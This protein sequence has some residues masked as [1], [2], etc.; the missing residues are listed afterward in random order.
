MPVYG[1]NIVRLGRIGGQG[2]CRYEGDMRGQGSGWP[3]YVWAG[4]GAG[5]WEARAFV[6]GVGVVLARRGGWGE[7]YSPQPRTALAWGRMCRGDRKRICKE[8]E[9]KKIGK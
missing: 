4:A 2:L 8:P 6:W 1:E 9:K 3:G 5:V 7:N